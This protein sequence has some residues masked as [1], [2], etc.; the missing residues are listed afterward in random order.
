MVKE[1]IR[2]DND[3]PG[4]GSD[5]DSNSDGINS[6]SIWFLSCTVLQIITYL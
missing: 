4:T 2:K 3:A 1:V 6:V 5:E